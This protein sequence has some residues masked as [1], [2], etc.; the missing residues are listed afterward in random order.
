MWV[1]TYI[2]ESMLR[3]ITSDCYDQHIN[4]NNDTNTNYTYCSKT[5]CQL[6]HYYH[7]IFSF[8]RLNLQQVRSTYAAITNYTITGTEAELKVRK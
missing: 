3:T 4:P 8:I 6:V 2:L 1:N 7:S 5:K